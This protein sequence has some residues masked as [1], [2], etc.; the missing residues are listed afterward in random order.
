[1]END[2]C[3]IYNW[4]LLSSLVLPS[5]GECPSNLPLKFTILEQLRQNPVSTIIVF[6]YLMRSS[7]HMWQGTT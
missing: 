4:Q 2:R 5:L 1:M 7:L 6:S 3:K